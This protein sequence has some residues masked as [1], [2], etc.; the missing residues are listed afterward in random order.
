MEMLIFEVFFMSMVSAILIRLLHASIAL[1]ACLFL[2][3]IRHPWPLDGRAVA[4]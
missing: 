2:A 1:R 4:R 3:K